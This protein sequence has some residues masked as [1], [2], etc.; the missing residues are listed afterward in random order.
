MTDKKPLTLI[1]KLDNATPKMLM[2]VYAPMAYFPI[3][4][5]FAHVIGK[6]EHTEILFNYGFALIIF[7]FFIMAALYLLCAAYSSISKS[8]FRFV[9]I[10]TE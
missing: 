7:G 9:R 6:P 10:R 2:A 3:A 1:D 4:I 8:K 5:I